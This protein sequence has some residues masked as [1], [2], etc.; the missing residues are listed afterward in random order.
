MIFV[1]LFLLIALLIFNLYYTKFDYIAPNVVFNASFVFSVFMCTLYYKKWDVNLNYQTFFIIL[2]G[3]I[4]FSIICILLSKKGK[5]EIEYDIKNDYELPEYKFKNLYGILF[6]IL[7]IITIFTTALYV[8]KS[9]GTDLTHLRTAL[10]TYRDKVEFRGEDYSLPSY[11]N[12]LTGT[13]HAGGF[14]FI[15]LFL[16]NF[17]KNKKINW[18]TLINIII[19]LLSTFLEGS[20]SMAINYILF[21]ICYG[22]YLVN[23]SNKFEKSIGNKTLI[24]IV[25]LG[26]LILASFRLTAVFV[27]RDNTSSFS[28]MDY[29]A[30][31]TGAE[32]KN[33]DTYIV[34][35]N[36]NTFQFGKYT[37]STLYSTFAPYFDLD[38]TTSFPFKRINGYNLGNVY[39]IFYHFYK[40]L[41]FLGVFIF[42]G[43]MAAVAQWLYNMAKK[44]KLQG[45]YGINLKSIIYC[46]TFSGIF[47]SFFSNHFFGL[48]FSLSFIKY[49]VM[50]TIMN[51][52]FMKNEKM[53]FDF[54]KK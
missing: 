42:S 20:R 31:Y 9:V 13:M 30:L 54:L 11:L 35:D 12:I 49:L 32:I 45:E 38:S 15:A 25:L 53:R 29:I 39:T 23:Y 51:Y 37:F 7:G 28:T 46:Y 3:N 43:F 22:I 27:G 16:T 48:I 5:D 40:D 4:V 34:E 19:C 24:K 21:A 33:L 1:L 47:Y 36:D 6:L 14:W 10:Y 26:I 52:I 41:G 18:I 44:C 17:K 50:W 8:T 2:I